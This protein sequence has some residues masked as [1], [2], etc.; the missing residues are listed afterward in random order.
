MAIRHTPSP[1]TPTLAPVGGLTLRADNGESLPLDPQRWHAPATPDE[2]R[3]LRMVRGP[4]LDVGCGPGRIV[5]NLVR[6]G[7][8]ALGVDPSPAAV[9]LARRRGCLVLQRSVF[10]TLPGEGR[11][12]TV[13]LL[14]GNIGIGGDAVALL[15]RCRTLMHRAGQVIVEV[16]PP[17]CGWRTRRVRLERGGE[18]SAWF[19]WSVVGAET[20]AGLATIAGLRAHAVDHTGDGRWFAHLVHCE[21]RRISVAS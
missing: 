5:D 18:A 15:A 8:A 9:S 11:W 1:P 3:L 4:A 21:P 14:D 12:R 13:L 16:E 17:G 6:H 7:V 19:A 2:N 10:E 20:I